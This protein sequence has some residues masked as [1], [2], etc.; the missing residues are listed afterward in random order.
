MIL[1]SAPASGIGTT[2]DR[3]QMFALTQ[4]FH[5]LRGQIAGHLCF[6][7]RRFFCH[8]STGYRTSSG[9]RSQSAATE[10]LLIRSVT[11]VRSA[12]RDA[13]QN[14]LADEGGLLRVLKST[15]AG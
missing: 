9:R 12:P 6:R 1:G 4:I 11:A 3:R 14:D 7:S 8:R 15:R 5:E 13:V 10:R 2:I